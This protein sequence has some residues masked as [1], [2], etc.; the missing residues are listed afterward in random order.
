MGKSSLSPLLLLFF[1]LLAVISALPYDAGSLS[2]SVLAYYRFSEVPT[3]G[4]TMVDSSSNNLNAVYP[5][6]SAIQTRVWELGGEL[7]NAGLSLSPASL[8]NGGI[9]LP[10]L[11]PDVGFSF[12]F[13][14]EPTN[15][16]RSQ[17]LVYVKVPYIDPL[18]HVVFDGG[19]LAIESYYMYQRRYSTFVFNK[20]ALHQVLISVHTRV[21]SVYIDGN[22]NFEQPFDLLNWNEVSSVAV[23]IGKHPTLANTQAEGIFDELMLFAGKVEPSQASDIF[24]SFIYGNLPTCNGQRLIAI[25]N[26][27]YTNGSLLN[28]L[29]STGACQWGTTWNSNGMVMNGT[30]EFHAENY[31]SYADRFLSI[32]PSMNEMSVTAQVLDLCRVA[33]PFENMNDLVG[34]CR[35][36]G[37]HVTMSLCAFDNYCVSFGIATFAQRYEY[38][39]GYLQEGITLA[40][41][42][43]RPMAL[44]YP[45]GVYIQIRINS[46]RLVTFYAGPTLYSLQP[47]VSNIQLNNYYP[48]SYFNLLRLVD[49]SVN[50]ETGARYGNIVINGTVPAVQLICD[51]GEY[52]YDGFCRSCPQNSTSPLGSAHKSD[53]V[54]DPG[55]YFQSCELNEC[56]DR[57]GFN[58]QGFQSTNPLK[59]YGTAT[60]V[61]PGF[62]TLTGS[63]TS[64]MGG[65]FYQQGV[66]LYGFDNIENAFSSHFVFM[67]NRNGGDLSSQEMD[68][69][70]ADGM[71]FIMTNYLPTS[72]TGNGQTMGFQSITPSIIV[73][74]D[75]YKN[76][77]IGDVDGNHIGIDLNGSGRSVKQVPISPRW[78]DNTSW[79]CWVDYDATNLMLEVRVATSNTK[80]EFP[81]VSLAGS[82]LD[83]LG[84]NIYL[85]FTA[86]TGAQYS[87]HALLAWE[88]ETSDPDSCQPCFWGTYKSNYGNNL[89]DYCP[90]PS[91]TDFEASTSPDDCFCYAGYQRNGTGCSRC[92]ENYQSDGHGS[93]CQPCPPNMI[94]SSWWWGGCYCKPG[95]YDLGNG[96]CQNINECQSNYIECRNGGTC[97]DSDGSYECICPLGWAGSACEFDINEC[98]L[99]WMPCLN[100]GTCTNTVGSYYCT[101]PAGFTGTHC[102]IDIDE[103]QSTPSVCNE[104]AICINTVGTYTCACANNMIGDGFECHASVGPQ[105]LAPYQQ[106]VFGRYLLLRWVPEDHFTAHGYIIEID[107]SPFGATFTVDRAIEVFGPVT[108]ALIENLLPVTAYRIRVTA[109]GLDFKSPPSNVV[110]VTTLASYPD[111][112]T[113]EFVTTE[114][115]YGLLSWTPGNPNGASVLGYLIQCYRNDTHNSTITQRTEAGVTS[116]VLD[117]LA[118][119]VQ[120]VVT[121]TILSDKGDSNPSSPLVIMIGQSN[122]QSPTEGNQPS[123]APS[124]N[125]EPDRGG[126]NGGMIAGI[127]IGVFL[128]IALIAGGLYFLKKKRDSGGFIQLGDEPKVKKSSKK[129]KK[130]AEKPKEDDPESKEPELNL[131]G[132]S[133]GN[134]DYYGEE[135]HEDAEDIDDHQ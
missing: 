59:Y 25:D 123:D 20:G 15:F 77:D 17:T 3:A 90:Y 32:L 42:I 87:T 80:P 116:L 84:S 23:T 38:F 2:S 69:V 27:L 44:A 91:S 102:E 33:N 131:M 111:P 41:S 88:F 62:I 122:T 94:S 49:L 115:G 12:V 57:A 39:A 8:A 96:T 34:D 112:A 46:L 98:V 72:L 5:S 107:M 101:C 54:C 76:G 78:N 24:K 19:K 134:E 43:S 99:E 103:C 10:I 83:R 108:Q 30:L 37:K 21:I 16:N 58:Y 113:V 130:Q 14:F 97:H 104:N 100:E 106:E 35:D 50:S 89:C 45:N 53:C 9:V 7:L 4:A 61:N 31:I 93:E 70:G 71:A 6:N 132:S 121:V 66:N 128:F 11:T 126:S 36:Y 105:L 1:S 133:T 85:G 125:P 92:P 73:E 119:R 28:G 79:H 109:V 95:Y 65:V 56:W 52:A 29:G 114:K 82:I 118:P 26:F 81:V 74:F 13:L 40:G 124:E 67:I 120:Y 127:I 55:Y 18:V 86:S 51:V 48:L 129:S 22:L 75:T 63:S 117:Q 60:L 110:Q 135:F 64:Q 47:I 68:G